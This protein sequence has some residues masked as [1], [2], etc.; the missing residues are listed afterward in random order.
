MPLCREHQRAL[1]LPMKWSWK[2]ARLAG[3]DVFMHPT[4][5]LLLAWVGVADFLPGHSLTAAARGIAFVLLLFVVVVLHELGHALT[6]RRFG[7]RTLDITL[8]PIGGVARLERMPDKPL[9][10]LLVALAGPAVNVVLAVIVFLAVA[11]G[12]QFSEFASLGIFGGSFLARLFQVNVALAIFNL[13]PAFPMDG[14]RVL[15]ALLAL[16]LDYVRATN[17]AAAIGQGMAVLLGLFGLAANPMLVLIALFVYLGAGQEARLVRM[18]AVLN[19]ISANQVMI[20]DFRALSPRD[21]LGRAAELLL[22]GSQHDFPVV[23]DGRLVGLLT[24]DRL[25]ETLAQSGDTVAVQE[26]M[27]RHVPAATAAETAEDL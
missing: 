9:Q 17:I 12:R 21:P 16:R 8:L 10:E 23:E 7:I 13:L 3:I 14:G 4:F 5:L 25:V 27:D 24:R 6:A 11:F 19:G 18:K 22:A 1:D 15:R 20:T 26:A 2:I